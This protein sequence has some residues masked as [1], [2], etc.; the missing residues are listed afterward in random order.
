VRVRTN[1]DFTAVDLTV[2][3]VPAS[4]ED[5]ATPP[6]FL[7]SLS[8]APAPGPAA[9]VAGADGGHEP[10]P[11][12]SSVELLRQELQ[13]KNEYLQTTT[14]ELETANEELK[15]AN[16]E[17][18]SVNEELQSANEELET[19][20]EELQSI[21]EELTTVNT[22]LQQ[23]VGAL[24]Q[25]NNDLN[26]LLAGTGVGT[27]FVDHQQHIRR[28]TPTVAQV[29]NLIPTDV[30]RPLGHLVSKLVAYD[31]LTEEVQAVLDTLVPREVE[32]QTKAGEW[33]LMRIRPYRTLE[34]VI[35]GAVITFFD[36][37]ERK[38][39]QEVLRK[40]A[41]RDGAAT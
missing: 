11:A 21:N 34:N 26:N 18:Q 9:A 29:V 39:A 10:E 1:G 12:D 23:K 13:A 40:N 17:L 16:E 5:P 38:A 41:A 37:T 6:L 7:V 8:E 35:E 31:R 27:I 15:S 24:T 32:V 3:P 33:F 19:S 4:P 14:E 36:I 30:G 25:A 28:F 2:R 20:K 22:E